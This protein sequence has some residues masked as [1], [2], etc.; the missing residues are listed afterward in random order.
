MKPSKILLSAL[1]FI[2][3]PAPA[4]PKDDLQQ[5]QRAISESHRKLQQQQGEQRRLQSNIRQTQNEL[6]NIRREL[7][8]LTRRRQTAWRE[9]QAMQ[10]K[11]DSLQT[12]IQGTQAQAARLLNSRYRHPQPN[13]VTLFLQNADP[14][15]KGR[16]LEYLRH[17]NQANSQALA[18]LQH[19]RQELKQQQ[20]SINQQLQRLD[21]L[22]RQQ[23]NTAAR[24][25]RQHQQQQHQQQNLEQDISR[26]TAKLQTLRS[27]ER[28][29]NGLIAS[30]SRRSAQ[31]QEA[32]RQ[33][34]AAAAAQQRRQQQTSR[35]AQARSKPNPQ[36][37]VENEL[38]ELRPNESAAPPHNTPNPNAL[39]A[40]D[41]ALEAPAAPEPQSQGFSRMQ[42]RLPRPAAGSISGRFGQARPGGGTWKGLFISTPPA[43]VRSIAAGEIAYAAPLQGYGNTV[44]IDHGDGYLSIYTGL[45]QIS[46][47]SG[48]SVSARQTIGRSG[49]LPGGENG[50]YFEIRYRNQAMNPSSWVN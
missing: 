23:Q 28:R 5:V 36:R 12:R 18:Q 29:L 11:L 35:Q 6:D 42:G 7:D 15:Q 43:P 44:I 37:P 25:G 30:L 50:L 48:S 13:A 40:E 24:L 32:Q 41:L 8:Q 21:A 9:L 22:K 1:L 4:A 45:S 10:A 38:N 16:Q 19:S 39:T 2:T 14:Q 3:L 33:R 31:R 17:L 34:R 47:G 46:A 49:S 20:D 26:E 27:D